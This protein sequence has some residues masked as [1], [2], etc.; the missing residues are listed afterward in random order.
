MAIHVSGR[1]KR[2]HPWAPLV[3]FEMDGFDLFGGMSPICSILRQS[4]RW[5]LWSLLKFFQFREVGN[6][7]P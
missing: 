3:P 2:D 7:H 5:A 4:S 1:L 6:S